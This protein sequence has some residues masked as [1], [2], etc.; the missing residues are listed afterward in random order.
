MFYLNRVGRV[1]VNTHI[2]LFGLSGAGTAYPS[3][4]PALTHSPPEISKMINRNRIPEPGTTIS[5]F[6]DSLKKEK[7]IKN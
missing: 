2:F 6:A 1:T 4:A 3:G 5:G 7:K